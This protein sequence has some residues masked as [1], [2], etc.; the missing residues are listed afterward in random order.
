MESD[1]FTV[2]LGPLDFGAVKSYDVELD[3]IMS[4]GW[5]GSSGRFPSMS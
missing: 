3:Q 1:R 5:C 2:F 4:L